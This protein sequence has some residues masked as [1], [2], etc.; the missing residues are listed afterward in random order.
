MYITAVWRQRIFSAGVQPCCRIYVGKVFPPRRSFF[1]TVYN[2]YSIPTF[3][4]VDHGELAS[5]DNFSEVPSES[6]GHS[7]PILF[8]Y[9]DNIAQLGLW[10]R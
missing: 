2:L 6:L 9:D 8:L 5:L 10:V 1:R 3:F 4:E 7:T